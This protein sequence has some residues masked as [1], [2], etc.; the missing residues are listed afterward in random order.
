MEQSKSSAIGISL[1]IEVPLGLG[2][3]TSKT[4]E[5]VYFIRVDNNQDVLQSSLIKSNYAKDGRVYLLNISSGKYMAVAYFYK[6]PS[7]EPGREVSYLVF[8][9][10]ELVE[11]TYVTITKGQ[12]SF[13][14][15]YILSTSILGLRKFREADDV[16]RYYMNMMLPPELPPIWKPVERTKALFDSISNNDKEFLVYATYDYTA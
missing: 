1:E 6:S 4:I 7:G 9:P 13:A 15:S 3:L 2:W 8:F 11:Q 14:G 12:I 16:Q 10:K 5:T